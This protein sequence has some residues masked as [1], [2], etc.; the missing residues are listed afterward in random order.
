MKNMSLSRIAEACGGV[1]Y[2]DKALADREAASI[3]TDS[4]QAAEGCLFVAVKGERA[5]GH[6]FIPAVF[7]QGALGVLSEKILEEPGGPYILVDSSLQAVKRIAEYYRR[8]LDVKV[9]GITGSVGK[10]STKEVVASVLSEKYNVLKTLGN[11]NNE[12]GLPL[13][14]FRLRQEHQVAVLEMGISD[15]GEMHRLSK[16]A[17]PDICVITNIG[18][19]HLEFLKDRDGILRAKSEIFDYMSEDGAIVLNGDDDKL[20]AIQEVRGIRPVFFGVESDSAV[21]ADHIEP[22]GMKGI[23]CEIHVGDQ[24]IPVLIPIPGYHMVLNALAAAA[25]GTKLGLSLGQIRDGIE[26]LESLS[27]R[28][29]IIEKGR[30][31]I[32]DDCYNAN[33]VSMKASLDVLKDAQHRK[34]AILGDMFELGENAAELHASVGA[35]AA[36]NQIDLLICVGEISRHMAQAAFETGG[37]QEVLQVPTLEA[38]LE[39]LP[40]LVQEDDT[41]LVKASHGMHF[42]KVVE[43]LEEL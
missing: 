16:I 17:R 26:K 8:Q 12:L 20:A 29:H 10:T 13:T 1:Y 22:K 34:V 32:I 38:L 24:S 19:C 33:P 25:V 6:D 4:R 36:G 27:G 43:R 11:F 7:R 21:Y 40:K 37:C 39:V 15:F 3:T 41:I 23:A 31:V 35:H 28:F 30:M 2:G 18:Q 42:E 5:D 14:I 9:V